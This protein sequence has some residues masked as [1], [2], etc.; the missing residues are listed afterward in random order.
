VL[1]NKIETLGR[2]FVGVVDSR[3]ENERKPEASKIEI[4]CCRTRNQEKPTPLFTVYRSNIARL[5]SCSTPKKM[6]SLPF[7]LQLYL[8]SVGV[9]A[10]D[11]D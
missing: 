7:L 5:L 9:D 3:R 1:E 4:D 10:L 11:D 8:T 2:L 6:P